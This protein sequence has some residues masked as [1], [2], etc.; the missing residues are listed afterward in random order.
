[1][2]EYRR[3]TPI[4]GAPF[5]TKPLNRAAVQPSSTSTAE[6]APKSPVT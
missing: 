4:E 6:G 1:V 5:F 3:G 2:P